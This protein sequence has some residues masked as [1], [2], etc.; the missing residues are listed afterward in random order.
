MHNCIVLYCIVLYCIVLYCIVLY[1]TA[2]FSLQSLYYIDFL[3]QGT[4]Y[5]ISLA[6]LMVVLIVDIGKTIVIK[7]IL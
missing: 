2:V 4:I 6:A 3:F 1:C 7:L 5:H